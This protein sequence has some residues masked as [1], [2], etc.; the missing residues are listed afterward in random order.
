MSTK[1]HGPQSPAKEGAKI[2]GTPYPVCGFAMLLVIVLKGCHRGLWNIQ[3]LS[4]TVT[5]V[6]RPY[7]PSVRAVSTGAFFDTHTYG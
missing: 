4:I 6:C 2:S 1:G 7:G 3:R 5:T